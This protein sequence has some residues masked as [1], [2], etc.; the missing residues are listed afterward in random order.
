MLLCSPVPDGWDVA[1]RN[2]SPS[3]LEATRRRLMNSSGN[4]VNAVLMQAGE[5]EGALH[6]VRPIVARP[7]GFA[8]R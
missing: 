7:K 1:L 3:D 2:L 8:T 4:D 6:L 5:G